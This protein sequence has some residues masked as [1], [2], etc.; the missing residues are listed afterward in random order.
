MQ[1]WLN[2]EPSLRN[3]NEGAEMMLK[4]SHNKVLYQNVMRNPV[5]FASRIEYELKK[6]MPMRL[7]RMTS[8]AV[9]SMDNKLM[10]ETKKLI[11]AHDAPVI[12]SDNDVPL[13]AKIAK[14]KRADHDQLPE[15]IQKLWDDNGALFFKIKEIYNTLL[16]MMDAQPCDR[17]EYLKVLQDLDK[18]Y[19]QNLAAYDSYKA[20]S[21]QNKKQMDA[22][23][24]I[25]AVSAARTF[26]SSNKSKLEELLVTMRKDE[27]EGRACPVEKQKYEDLLANVQERYDFLIR[28]GNNVSDEQLTALT[29]LGLEP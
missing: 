17:Y 25:K 16:G 3:L 1:A 21:P 9:V 2:M 28:G 20:D 14:G 6:R 12:D 11:D 26:L 4:L 13:S 5:K 29:K 27:E 23:E 8:E 22:S 18:R 15:N 24:M 7:D 19:H 10:P